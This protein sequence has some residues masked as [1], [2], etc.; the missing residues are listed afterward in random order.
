MKGDGI[1]LYSYMEGSNNR[2]VIPVYQR[3]Y[4]WKIEN[5]K[6]LYN[7]L[8]RLTDDKEGNHFFGSIV[9][10]VV[11]AGSTTEYHIIDGQQRLTT[12]TLLL[13]AI[14]K[15]VEKG[16]VY[17]NE[18]DL[19]NQ[20]MERFIISKWAKE[21]DRIKLIPVKRDRQAL[22]SLIFGEEDEYVEN[23][24]LTI[25]FK[26]FY[27]RLRKDSDLID[28]IYSAIQ[29]L[30]VISITLEKG[31]DAQLIFESLNSTGLALSEG[32]KIRNFILM[33]LPLDEQ[34]KYFEKY[35]IKIEDLTNKRIDN[36]VRNYLSIKTFSTPTMAKVYFEFKEYVNKHNDSLEKLLEDM[37][38]Y[39]KFYKK[40]LDGESGFNNRDL[41]SAMFNFM[42]MDRTV[43][44]PFFMEIFSLQD[45]GKLNLDDLI[46]IYEI[47]ES[48]L[49]RRNICGVGTNALNKIFLNLNKDIIRYDGSTDKY[50]EKLKYNLINKRDSGRF[51]KDEEF[52][53]NLN[54]KE[55]YLM[56][57]GFKNY[58]FN[59]IENYKTVET[60]DIYNH[61]D[62][63]T[64]SIEHIMPQKLNDDWFEE[65][66]DNAEEIHE[67]WIHKLGNLTITGYNSDMGN[68]S[69]TKKRDGKHGFKKS[70]IR[71][72]QDLALLDSWGEEEIEKRQKDLL[73]LSV[74]EI[75]KYPTT[76]F[77]LQREDLEYTS[78][79]DDDY[80]L[81]GKRILKINFRGEE[82]SFKNW[83]D[84]F[85]F[86]IKIL[87]EEDKSQLINLVREEPRDILG[88]SFSNNYNAF[89]NYEKID[90]NIFVSTNNN[91]NT[92]IKILG[93]LFELY[94]ED[95]NNLIFYFEDSKN[96]D[97]E[98]EN[99][100]EEYWNYAIPIIRE[101]NIDNETF[102]NVTRSKGSWITGT[103]GTSGFYISCY[104][105]MKSAKV[106]MTL[107]KPDKE[108]N[109]AAFDYLYKNKENIEN[110]LGL[111]LYWNRLD[112]NKMS[113]IDVAIEN[114][115][116]KDK[117]NWKKI[118][119]FQAEMS[120][121]FYKEFVPRLRD[122]KNEYNK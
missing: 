79:A 74:Y 82:S 67:K 111:K 62:D 9:S 23:S 1:Q 101:A 104:Y 98:P 121:A 93:K 63:G 45:E 44:E 11:G 49:F 64:Y 18:M 113:T 91:T 38:R 114:I 2:Y 25:N 78:L 86:V 81:K 50:V 48:Y 109:K 89:H 73:N 75:W 36:F 122:F 69:F 87:H 20:I 88:Y 35:W 61:L 8:L 94:D 16:E 102:M 27:E 26:Y 120:D 4:D 40:L 119:K 15:L 95:P 97:R 107:N 85:I 39:S 76:N 56:R 116:S 112:D 28:E 29:R 110:D 92:K 41:D 80:D 30:Q 53:E 117:S 47:I 105:Y 99:I 103:I 57:G 108:V 19:S 60:K 46:G 77:E 37:L 59:K 31:D 12:V 5:C 43:T 118:A 115:N 55:I 17:S 58:L 7:D 54:N 22:H 13:L 84:A 21:D 6:Q 68:S 72:N 90:E 66:G 32:D 100:R 65:L 83:V 52:Y 96:F 106:S 71:M 51:P 14:D 3:R 42:K 33:N 24:N 34:N 70:G 10:D